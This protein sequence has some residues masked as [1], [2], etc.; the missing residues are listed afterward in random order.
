MKAERAKLAKKKIKFYVKKK[1]INS[2]TM[3]IKG[4]QHE[5]VC[6]NFLHKPTETLW[7]QGPGTRDF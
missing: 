6:L 5:I 4:T 2:W 3:D 1:I 7:S